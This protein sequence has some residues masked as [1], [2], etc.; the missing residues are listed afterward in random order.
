MPG[1]A[2]VLGPEESGPELGRERKERAPRE[3]KASPE[4]LPAAEPG[5]EARERAPDGAE[6]GPRGGERARGPEPARG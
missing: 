1:W 3:E 2:R 4:A 6:S 5:P